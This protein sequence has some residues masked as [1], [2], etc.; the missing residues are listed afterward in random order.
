ME[1]VIEIAGR[2]VHVSM[3]PVRP[4]EGVQL[5]AVALLR[6][7]SVQAQAGAEHERRLAE[8]TD[9]N[10]KLAR[11]AKQLR[12]LAWASKEAAARTQQSAEPERR[13][14]R[15]GE[16]DLQ[17]VIDETVQAA[18]PLTGGKPVSVVRAHEVGLPS[19][20]ADEAQVREALFN[21]LTNAIEYVQEGQIAVSALRGDGYVVTSIA[22]TGARISPRYVEAAYDVFSQ[23]PLM[24]PAETDALRTKLMAIRR[25]VE[26]IG[27]KTWVKNKETLIIYFSL[28]GGLPLSPGA[29][30][31]LLA[32]VQPD[33]PRSLLP[34]L[35]SLADN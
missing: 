18:A 31:P 11:A 12:D 28:P 26:A 35:P 2:T 6:D 21:L 1:A 16:V 22:H 27:G 14:T 4:V 23:G 3:A 7:V 34:S 17:R 19:V 24:G 13:Y 8:L 20:R 32:R 29:E 10:R 33:D 25:S 9:Q 30:T 15:P 5:G